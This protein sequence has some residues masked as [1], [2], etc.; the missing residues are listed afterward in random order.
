MHYTETKQESV[1]LVNEF[2]SEA[3]EE[4]LTD[5]EE[6]KDWGI[7]GGESEAKLKEMVSDFLSELRTEKCEAKNA[8]MYEL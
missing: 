6:I 4:P 1:D 8:W 5:P 3:G 2:L 7:I